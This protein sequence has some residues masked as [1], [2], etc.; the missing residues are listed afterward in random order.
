M[1][2][3]TKRIFD[4]IN[5]NVDPTNIKDWLYDNELLNTVGIYYDSCVKSA[6]QLSLINKLATQ[7]NSKKLF[8]VCEMFN[9]NDI[10]YITFKGI[11]LSY[12]IYNNPHSRLC[13][14]ID[15]FVNSKDFNNALELL[16]NN[17]YDFTDISTIK[18]EHHVVLNDG[19]TTLELH[20]NILN[21]FTN[22][23]EYY[24]IN[25]TNRVI[26]SDCDINTFSITATL[27]HLLYHLYM[28]TY[29][30]TLNYDALFEGK[31][32]EKANRFLY[33]AYEI[34]LFSEKYFKEINWDEIANDIKSQK[35]RVIFQK[36]IYDILEIFPETFPNQIIDLVN[37]LDYVYDER[38]ALCKCIMDAKL[39]NKNINDILS[40]C[41]DTEWNKKSDRNIL[42]CNNGEFILD[43][44]II[45]DNEN[46]DYNLTCK[47]NMEKSCNDVKLEFRITNND[48]YFSDIGSYDTQTSDGVH[49]IICGTV[50][51]S[52]N[53]IF[54]FPK[55]IDGKP[56]VVPVD[57]FKG[58]NLEIDESLIQATCNKT[59]ADYTITVVLKE[60]FLKERS[61]DKYFYL[62]LVISDC[63]SKTKKRKAELILSNPYTEWYNPIYFAKIEP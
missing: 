19:I 40:D 11:I 60:K 30:K 33:R 47:V 56:I 36:M 22:I 50:K 5:K 55:I 12:R 17:G 1:A 52:Y 49:L 35:L 32:V 29:L 62:G 16:L 41:I 39:S 24:L 26:I 42:I 2:N 27:L 23:D 59:D 54:L 8:R 44:T 13:G 53:S 9:N 51:Y 4:Y 18:S 31:D 48:F 37:N 43:K 46:D 63:S 3:A 45:R 34:A 28:D 20:K 15:I 14:D 57:V 25:H 38:D 61:I 6:E 58:K 10:D 7:K 21:P